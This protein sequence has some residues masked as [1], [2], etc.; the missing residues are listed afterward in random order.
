M[1][2]KYK[3]EQDY[4]LN[5]GQIYN[6]CLL[7]CFLIQ[8]TNDGFVAM[9]NPFDCVFGLPQKVEEIR[10]QVPATSSRKHSRKRRRYHRRHQNHHEDNDL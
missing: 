6:E 9:E 5:N 4:Q 1:Q 2:W 8:I 3:S 7:N 10:R